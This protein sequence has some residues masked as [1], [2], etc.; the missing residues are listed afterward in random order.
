[1]F[2]EWSLLNVSDN[3]FLCDYSHYSS[4][5]SRSALMGDEKVEEKP[6]LKHLQHTVIFRV[7]FS[8]F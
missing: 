2:S 1:M 8:T 4:L 6:N 5:Y 7:A 3:M